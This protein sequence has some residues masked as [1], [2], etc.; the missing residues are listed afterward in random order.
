MRSPSEPPLG[1]SAC[2]HLAFLPFAL[3]CSGRIL[4]YHTSEE[5]VFHRQSADFGGR[6][7]FGCA[8]GRA[9]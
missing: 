8:F 3:R 5:A 4:T 1:E 6:V 9:F 2:T 7:V